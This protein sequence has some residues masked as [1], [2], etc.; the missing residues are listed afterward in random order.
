MRWPMARDDLIQVEGIVTDISKGD[1]YTITLT[2]NDVQIFAKLCGKMR[3]HH[4]RVVTGDRVTVGVSPY[5][6]THGLI[7]FRHR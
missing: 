5:D 2:D 6:V 1:L 7:T 4:I 3:R